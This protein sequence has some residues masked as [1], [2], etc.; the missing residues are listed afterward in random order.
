M[1]VREHHVTAGNPRWTTSRLRP[2]QR[3]A[4][5]L[6]GI[7][8]TQRHD[9]LDLRPLTVVPETVHRAGRGKLC[10]T[11][12]RHE[13]PA[14]NLAPLLEGT[15]QAVN[16]G[17]PSRVLLAECALA[18]EH[19]MALQQLQRLQVRAFGVARPG[20]QEGGHQ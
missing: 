12:A 4:V 14:P 6:G 2:H 1:A 13:V 19:T 7:R 9:L 18:C 16:R 8:G 5:G 10:T 17:E 15:Q 3:R 11:K 20:L